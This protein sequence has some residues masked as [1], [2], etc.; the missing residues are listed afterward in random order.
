MK[1]RIT[2][3]ALCCAL[4]AACQMIVVPTESADTANRL[5]EPI[6][7]DTRGDIYDGGSCTRED[8]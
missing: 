2:L 5:D 7:P 1:T 6:T 8:D 3:V 4:L